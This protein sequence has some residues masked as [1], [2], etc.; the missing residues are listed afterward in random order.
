MSHVSRS[1]RLFLAAIT[2][3]IAGT[4]AHA[5]MSLSTT[6]DLAL[7]NSPRVRMAQ[8][9]F[10][11]AKAALQETRDAYVP[12]ISTNAGY[13]GSSGVPLSLPVVFSISAQSLVYTAGQQDYIRAAHSALLA[14]S[15]ALDEARAEV[16][17]DA[18]STYVSLNNALERRKT[19]KQ[20]REYAN[21]LV[22]V[23]EDR[24]AA[25][26]DPKVETTRSRRTAT[27]LKLQ[28]LRVDDEIA[29]LIGH[30]SRVT[31]ISN[32]AAETD[33]SSI[34]A[35]LAPEE[36]AGSLTDNDGLRAAFANAQAKSYIAHGDAR[37]RWRPQ[38]SF[39]SSYN[40]ISTVGTD[41]A[42]YYPR[43]ANNAFSHNSFNIGFSINLPI[44]DLAH[45]AK[46]RGS[47]A[48]AR[49]ALADSEYQRLQFRD[50]RQKLEHA[51]AELAAQAELASLDRDLAQ[52]QLETVQ[53]QLQA[54]AADPNAPQLSPKDEQNA[55]L[56]VSQKYLDFLSADLQL[57][58]TQLTLMRQNGR[59]GEWLRTTL[60]TPKPSTPKNVIVPQR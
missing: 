7:R 26:V 43:F 58:T 11:K 57:K 18:A 29:D 36:N 42:D 5:Q 31:G 21:R 37:Y 34:P 23:T 40:R 47:A 2:L 28:Q 52:D 15:Y 32:P 8:A 9:E 3:A 24:F 55:H 20:G 49:R 54:S 27:A 41:Y 30:L 50:G 46:A 13:G 53:L 39:A 12:S 4:S 59:L 17:E 1:C 35:F 48:E 22:Q 38:I 33:A 10:D 16:A 45:Q 14:A 51:A 44:L 56:Q 6:V 19:L 60:T 25:G